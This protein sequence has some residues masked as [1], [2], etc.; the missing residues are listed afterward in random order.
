MKVETLI[1]K[2]KKLKEKGLSTEEIADELNVSFE[3]AL[4]LLTR[5]TE[6]PPSD[7]YV[8]WRTITK[9]SRLRCVASALV[10]LICEKLSSVEVIVGVATSGIPLASLVAEE[11]VADLAIYYPKKLN[12]GVLSENFARVSGKNC[13]IV[14]DIIST[15]KT[16]REAVEVVRA[17]EGKVL[18]IAVI[19]D[20]KGVDE[21]DSVPVLSLM[22]I[23]R[24]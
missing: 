1:E 17:S 9:P 14:D 12:K 2:A 7:I 21:I 13:A 4:W 15:G 16:V 18:G 23:I 20:K 10:D 6:V 11:L 24:I 5:A 22:K 19:I 8:E 3:T